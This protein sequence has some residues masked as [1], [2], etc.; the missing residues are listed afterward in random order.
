MILLDIK[1]KPYHRLIFNHKEK[2]SEVIFLYRIPKITEIKYLC[3]LSW[4]QIYEAE[5]LISGTKTSFILRFF[6]PRNEEKYIFEL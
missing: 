2:R 1:L 4:K 5:N 6:H 3:H